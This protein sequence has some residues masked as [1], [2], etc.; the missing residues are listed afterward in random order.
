MGASMTGLAGHAQGHP[1]SCASICPLMT[2]PP[3]SSLSHLISASYLLRQPTS[4]MPFAP[5]SIPPPP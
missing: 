4:F 1:C 5:A 3:Q 2:L